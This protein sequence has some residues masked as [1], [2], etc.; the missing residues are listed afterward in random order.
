MK[1]TE[2]IIFLTTILSLH[3]WR[4]VRYHRQPDLS[5]EDGDNS[6][7][8]DPSSDVSESIDSSSDDSDIVESSRDSLIGFGQAGESEGIDMQ[9]QENAAVILM[10]HSN[11]TTVV[12]LSWDCVRSKGCSRLKKEQ[13]RIGPNVWAQPPLTFC[14]VWE[15]VV[16]CWSAV[17]F[18]GFSGSL[19]DEPI[20]SEEDEGPVILC[21]C[22]PSNTA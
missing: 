4:Q 12:L 21:N 13:L 9:N 8:P 10:S 11:V 5:S 15:G 6:C 2:K 19:V 18:L 1:L 16:V 20:S 17:I 7:T 14:G 3:A 22:N